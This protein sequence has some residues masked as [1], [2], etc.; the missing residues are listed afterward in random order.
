M[1]GWTVVYL[2]GTV[3]ILAARWEAMNVVACYWE[4]V[5]FKHKQ[6]GHHGD[7]NGKDKEGFGMVRRRNQ[8]WH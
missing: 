5:G 6:C 7:A 3:F 4:G 8:S 2:L 1:G